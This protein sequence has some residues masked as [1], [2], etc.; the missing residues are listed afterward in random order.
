M[1]EYLARVGWLSNGLL[2]AQVENRDQTELKLV[3]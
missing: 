1:Q 3:G 2:T